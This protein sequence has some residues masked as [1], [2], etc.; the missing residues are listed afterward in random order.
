MVNATGTNWGI[1]EAYMELI[2]N[3][4]RNKLIIE[5]VVEC[6]KNDR[7]PLVL[8]KLIF[9]TI[10]IQKYFVIKNVRFENVQGTTN[11]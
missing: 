8:T 7:T 3:N 10:K 9:L 4:S 1:N 2:K 6:V 5:D 11:E